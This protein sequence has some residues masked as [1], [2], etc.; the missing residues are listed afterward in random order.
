MGFNTPIISKTLIQNI[1]FQVYIIS[2][3]KL[4]IWVLG[5]GKSNNNEWNF[6]GASYK[7]A[8]VYKYQNERC[9]FFEEINEDECT[10]TIYNNQTIVKKTFIDKEPYMQN[11][12]QSI[13]IP[14]CTLNEWNNNEKMEYVFNYHLKQRLSIQ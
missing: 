7:A 4:R 5:V 9:I 11:I 6:A 2:L 3:E 8:F 14:N 12:I 10:L 13:Q 1:P